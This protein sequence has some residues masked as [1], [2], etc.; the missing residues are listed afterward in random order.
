M[1]AGIRSALMIAATA[2][3]V[4]LAILLGTLAFCAWD[5]T[6]MVAG[7]PRMLD[8]R[9][10][11]EAVRTRMA[12]QEEI[13]AARTG[14]LE[15]LVRLRQDVRAELRGAVAVLD[16]RLESTEERTEDEIA[17]TRE[18][19]VRQLEALRQDMA[20][21]FERVNALLDD[22]DQAVRTLTPQALGLVAAAKVTAGETAQAMRTLEREMP[23]IVANVRQTSANVT[24]ITKPSR[25]YLRLARI[26]A[27]AL[28][29]WIIGKV[30]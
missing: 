5:L 24:Q 15:E 6:R 8:T 7:L 25:W 23:A 29:G 17:L 19:A 14:L 20:G 13:A 2:W 27:P 3:R 9:L 1:E 22:T 10:A 18:E 21:S 26:V 11:E 28:G 12:A 4:A 30:Q 16:R